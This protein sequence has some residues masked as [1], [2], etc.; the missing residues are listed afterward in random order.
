VRAVAGAFKDAWAVIQAIAGALVDVWNDPAAAWQGFLDAMTSGMLAAGEFIAGIWQG[1]VDQVMAAIN[2]ISEGWAK[3]K[4]LVGLGDD[5]AGA[6]GA[7]TRAGI[8]A[9]QAQLGAASASPLGAQTS[10]S[11][12]NA[13]QVSKNTTVQVGAVNVQTQATDAEG[14]SKAVGSSLTSQMKQ[15]ANN[16]DDG[17]LA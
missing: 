8:A 2:F 10:N 4:A 3:A 1:I 7:T 12:N 15:A 6:E 16:Y 13:K 14:I 5:P 11:I 17:V 9:G